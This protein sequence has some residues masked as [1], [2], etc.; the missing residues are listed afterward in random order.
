MPGWPDDH[1]VEGHPVAV[2]EREHVSW[3]R[4]HDEQVLHRIVNAPG[5][6]GSFRQPGLSNHA[7]I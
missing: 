1:H 5:L 4:I 3:Q 2:A 6:S 7:S